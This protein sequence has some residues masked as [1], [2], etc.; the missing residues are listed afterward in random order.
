MAPFFG[1]SVCGSGIGDCL[2]PTLKKKDRNEYNKR[3]NHSTTK[4]I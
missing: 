1:L 4:A 3:I 2:S